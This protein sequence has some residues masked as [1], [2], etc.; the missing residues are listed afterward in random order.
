MQITIPDTTTIPLGRNAVYGQLAVDL[1]R[2]PPHVHDYVYAYGLRQVLND[3]MAQ[4][5]DEDGNALTDDV[6]RAKAEKRLDNMYAGE[7]RARGDA[8]EPA[9]PV[10]A[11]AYK[12][13]KAAFTDAYKGVK[14]EGK[15]DA[16]LLALV[17][18]T[19][20][21][22][23]APPIAALAEAIERYLDKHPDVRKLAA[24]NVKERSA[25]AVSA[26]DFI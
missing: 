7:L 22:H 16:R 5:K 18:E 4:K 12:L 17:N 19:R 15:G 20:A 13:A 2:L 6:I 24:R 23:N 3:A 10:E 8:A 9:D 1:Q 11:E 25:R 26:E 21:E 14:G